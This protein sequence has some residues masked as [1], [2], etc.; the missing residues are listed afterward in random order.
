MQYTRDPI[1]CTCRPA[2]SQPLKKSNSSS[3]PILRLQLIKNAGLGNTT[4]PATT[5]IIKIQ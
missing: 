2:F 3:F 4:S 5:S 1:C